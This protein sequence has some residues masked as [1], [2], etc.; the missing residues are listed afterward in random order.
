MFY[1]G[2]NWPPKYGARN[3]QESGYHP[4]ID[5]SKYP[6]LGLSPIFFEANSY[7]FNHI[8]GLCYQEYIHRTSKNKRSDGDSGGNLKGEFSFPPFITLLGPS[9]GTSGDSSTIQYCWCT[10]RG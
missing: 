1:L 3:T 10:C 8:L 4:G 9:M 7:V 5:I 6:K 2:K